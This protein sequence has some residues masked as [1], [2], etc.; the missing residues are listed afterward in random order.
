MTRSEDASTEQLPILRTNYFQLP[1]AGRSTRRLFPRALAGGAVAVGGALLAD[2]SNHKGVV[3]KRANAY[4]NFYIVDSAYLAEHLH[5]RDKY[6]TPY[7]WYEDL[8]KGVK[9]F[10]QESN[11]DP[12]Y[13]TVNDDMFGSPNYPHYEDAQYPLSKYAVANQLSYPYESGALEDG[14]Y[15]A[16]SPT[17]IPELGLELLSSGIGTATFG[18]SIILVNNSRFSR[19][20]YASKTQNS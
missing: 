18:M 6:P 20:R 19:Y 5:P 1:P 4:G 8:P 14:N 7:S 11:F 10:W 16:L 17:Q 3:S 9:V 13:P 12:V 15:L 2:A